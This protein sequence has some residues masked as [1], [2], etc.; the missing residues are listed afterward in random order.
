MNQRAAEEKKFGFNLPTKSLMVRTQ[1]ETG[2]NHHKSADHF[3]MVSQHFTL[4]LVHKFLMSIAVKRRR[5]QLF[6]LL[7]AEDVDELVDSVR[8]DGKKPQT[9]K[10]SRIQKVLSLRRQQRER[11]QPPPTLRPSGFVARRRG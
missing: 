6:S 1:G 7:P 2:S 4:L 11:K 5:L 3:L 10:Q 8:A 9:T